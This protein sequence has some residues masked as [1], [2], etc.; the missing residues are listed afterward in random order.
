MQ[1]LNEGTAYMNGDGVDQDYEKASAFS[2]GLR[3]RK[4]E[5][6]PIRWYGI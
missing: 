2:G 5:S 1:T 6:D 3:S 4:H